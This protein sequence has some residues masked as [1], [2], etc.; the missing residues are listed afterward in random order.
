VPPLPPVK[1]AQAQDGI[2]ATI[3]NESVH[4]SV[5]RP[6]VIHFVSTSQPPNTIR[7][8]Q[9]WMLDSK[10]SCPGAKFQVAETKDAAVLTTE[11][12]KIEL[13]LKWGNVQ[14]SAVGGEN[15]LRERNSS[16]RAYEP[17]ELNGEKT[18]HVEDKF[19]P[20]FDLLGAMVNWVEKGTTPTSVVATG[21]AFPGRS[22][23]LCPYP[24]HAQYKGRNPE[25]AN[26]FECR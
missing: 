5:C 26:S 16:P 22:R 19:A 10:E 17:A 18:F 3:G 14:F 7:Q 8:S 9:P 6:A 23:P 13:S 4:I 1:Y 11:T 12:L 24:K 25:D 20:D 21:K 15:L 2:T